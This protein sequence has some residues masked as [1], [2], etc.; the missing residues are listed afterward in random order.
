[1]FDPFAIAS[2]ARLVGAA[3]EAGKA[4]MAIYRQD[5]AVTEK[6]D[7][8]PVTVADKAAE[9]IILEELR[10]LAPD[11]PVVAEEAASAGSIPE[12]GDRFFLVDPLDGTKEFVRKGGDFTVNIALIEHGQPVFG[13]V[14]APATEQLFVTLGRDV[15]V[16]AAMAVDGPRPDLAGGEGSRLR[17]RQPDSDGLAVV[18]SKSHMND[19]TRR[20]IDG[21]KV[22]ALRNAGSSLK[23]CLLAKAE[24]DVYPRFGPTMEWDTAAGHAVLSAAGGTVTRVDGSPFRY[25]KR[26]DGY[27][28]PYFIAWGQRPEAGR[29][30]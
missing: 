10:R 8:S 25:G 22:K 4:E 13:L 15:A 30:T 19:E 11:I 24:A 7:G 3:Q 26:Q 16:L 6:A 28:N 17:T 18:A 1:M 29:S 9:A 2:V 27:L 14:Y 23:F 20:Y 5:F 12:T 21:I